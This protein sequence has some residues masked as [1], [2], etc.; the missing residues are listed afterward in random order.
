M[1]SPIDAALIPLH[2]EVQKEIALLRHRRL[3]MQLG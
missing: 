1:K 3:E 2:A